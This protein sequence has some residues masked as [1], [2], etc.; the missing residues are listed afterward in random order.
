MVGFAWSDWTRIQSAEHQL[1]R[2]PSVRIVHVCLIGWTVNRTL[3]NQCSNPRVKTPQPVTWALKMNYMT[4][5]EA[6]TMWN[7]A[8]GLGTVSTIKTL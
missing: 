5:L 8:G 4:E 7:A 1:S 3:S 6:L 2:L